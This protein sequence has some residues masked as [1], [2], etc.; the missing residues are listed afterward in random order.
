MRLNNYLNKKLAFTGR[1][2]AEN[3]RGLPVGENYAASTA[4]PGLLRQ[5]L[6]IRPGWVQMRRRNPSEWGQPGLPGAQG[7]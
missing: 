1:I 7:S 3:Y 4:C 6:C 2:E 5:G